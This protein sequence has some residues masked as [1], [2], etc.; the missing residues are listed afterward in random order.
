MTFSS[1]AP[2]TRPQLAQSQPVSGRRHCC[3][4][5][6]TTFSGTTTMYANLLYDRDDLYNLRSGD[7]PAL[8]HG[9]DRRR[10]LHH[11]IRH[12]ALVAGNP[13]SLPAVAPYV[14]QRMTSTKAL[15]NALDR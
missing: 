2:P 7:D 6:F 3:L 15:R 10:V 8:Y 5:T 11:H 1:V 12:A 9:G 13:S 4:D 14:W